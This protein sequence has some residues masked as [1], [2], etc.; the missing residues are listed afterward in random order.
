M[1]SQRRNPS[2]C[3]AWAVLGAGVVTAVLA[4]VTGSAA[5][6]ALAG[7]YVF[8][9]NSAF[10]FD[11]P[12][13]RPEDDLAIAPDKTPLLPGGTA[14]FDNYTSYSRG[15][16]GV[17]VDIAGLPDPAAVSASDFQFRVGNDD[18]PSTWPVGPPPTDIEVRAGAGAGGSDRITIIWADNAIQNQ[19]LQVTVIGDPVTTGLM[20]DD[21]FYVGNAPGESRDSQTH[22]MVNATDMIAARENPRNFLNP[23]PVDF[24]YDFNRDKWVN[25]SDMVVARDNA[26]GFLTALQLITVPAESNSGGQAASLTIAVGDH[27]LLPDTPG[28][29]ITLH[30]SGG[31]PV[32]GVN[33]MVQVG[34]GGPEV[35]GTDG[36]AITGINLVPAGGIFDGNLPI[37]QADPPDYPQAAASYLA[38]GLQ[39][40]SVPADGVLAVLTIDTTGFQVGTWDLLLSG[41]LGGYR[42]DFADAS[43]PVTIANGTITVVPEPG[44]LGL[45]A[46]LGLAL[47]ARKKRVRSLVSSGD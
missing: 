23:A 44:T 34:D 38:I 33:L 22:A 46:A 14:T 5:G 28:Q 31:N 41:I 11:T 3:R 42:T 6:A 12:M 1:A 37:L 19:W 4:L 16:N 27:V 32:V 35:G 21:V 43:L 2:A 45:L 9:N 25:A 17:M 30:V 29:T 36:P 15:I 7:R 26:T 8:Y 20:D 39:G 24:R 18:D 13:P 40:M 47:C 10:D